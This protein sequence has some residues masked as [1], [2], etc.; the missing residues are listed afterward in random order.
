[1]CLIVISLV[2]KDVTTIEIYKRII[3]LFLNSFIEIFLREVILPYVIISEAT[4]VIM[5]GMLF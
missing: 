2:Q 3:W 4:I 1:M 5:E